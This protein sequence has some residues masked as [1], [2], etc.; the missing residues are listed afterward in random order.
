MSLYLYSRIDL[1]YREGIIRTVYWGLVNVPVYVSR[2]DL[3]YREGIIRTVYW[4]LV[5][6]PVFVL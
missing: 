1:E 3:G 6:V 2:I 5:N 4:G